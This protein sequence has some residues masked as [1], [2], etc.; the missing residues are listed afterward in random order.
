MTPF[1]KVGL[2]AEACSSITFRRAMG[3]Q[4]ASSLLLAG[5]QMTAQ[6]LE[7]AGLI[8][9]IF[10]KES[11]LD[12]V[13]KI[14]SRIAAH[15]AGALEANKQ[16]LV[17]P[18]REELLAANERECKMLHERGKTDE[19]RKAIEAFAQEQKAKRKGGNL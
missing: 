19:P 8:T 14:A 5:E 9:K 1:L 12:E 15:P 4:K 18:M 11:F 6:E 13:M 17:E 3:R 16:L 10:P 7:S 2:C